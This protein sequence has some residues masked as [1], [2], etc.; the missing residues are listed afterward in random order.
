MYS[1][2]NGDEEQDGLLSGLYVLRWRWGV[3]SHAYGDVVDLYSHDYGEANQ[4]E[5]GRSQASLDN[6][7]RRFPCRICK[8]L[9]HWGRE[10]PQAGAKLADGEAQRVDGNAPNTTDAQQV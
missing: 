5:R 7:K 1:H 9:G 2:D 4:F 10:C 8:K 3:P 6:L